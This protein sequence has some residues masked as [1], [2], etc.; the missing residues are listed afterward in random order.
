MLRNPQ[1]ALSLAA[2]ITQYLD[3]ASKLLSEPSVDAGSDE[4][5]PITYQDILAA[6]RL[7]ESQQIALDRL[8]AKTVVKD[9]P[10][11]GPEALADISHRANQS[12]FNLS[13]LFDDLRVF[14]VNGQFANFQAAISTN[15]SSSKTQHM[16]DELQQLRSDLFVNLLIVIR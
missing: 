13:Q 14:E 8:S 2:T 3:L 4:N 12:A 1:D 11:P 10:L 15:W 6:A 16:L 9:T 5:V 7:L